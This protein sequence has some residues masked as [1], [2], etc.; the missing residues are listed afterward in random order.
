MQENLKQKT[1]SK[2][3]KLTLINVIAALFTS[4]F[5]IDSIVPAASTG[6]SALIWY[7]ILGIT[8]YIPY[9]FVVGE[10]ASKI[11]DEG[12]VYAWVKK[13]LGV[14]FAKRTSWYYWVNVGI[15]APSIALYISQLIVYMWMPDVTGA[16]YNWATMGMAIAFMWASLAFAYF[17]ISENSYLYL[18]STIGKIIIVAFL[19]VG[20]FVYIGNGKGPETDFSKIPSEFSKAGGAIMFLP[21]LVY[22]I[23]GMEVVSGEVSKVKNPK[24]TM[25]R[26]TIITTLSLLVFY[27]LTTLAVQYIFNTAGVLELTGIIQ[28]LENAFGNGLA[29]KILINVLGIIFM[30]TMFIETMGWVSGANAGIMESAKNREVPKIFQWKNKKNMPFKATCLLGIIGTVELVLFTTIGQ[31][32]GG[33]AGENIFWALFGA[34]SNI[35]FMSY[36]FMFIA[37]IKMKWK[38]ELDNLQGFSLNKS[39]GILMS[40]LAMIV[41]AITWFLLLWNPD[42]DLLSQTLPISLSVLIALLMGEGAFLFANKKYR[43]SYWKG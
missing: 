43:N 40:I 20:M 19:F 41:L 42:Y 7:L 18:S 39:L 1:K 37:Y 13:A 33:S 17:P 25:A 30:Y 5:L 3:N 10:F 27:V 14:G 6:S 28:G 4:I 8:F 32:V 15:W 36:F 29:A 21:A 26:A 38:N 34:S 9:G 2:L 11:P 22:N 31:L 24:K 16:S 35:L 23:L 12:G